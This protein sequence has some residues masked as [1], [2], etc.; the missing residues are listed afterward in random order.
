MAKVLAVRVRYQVSGPATCC[1]QQGSRRE[2]GTVAE[3]YQH[4][5]ILGAEGFWCASTI[6]FVVQK[7]LSKENS[8]GAEL[9][10]ARRTVS[11]GFGIPP[12]RAQE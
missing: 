2:N 9:S 1:E 11:P 12:G 5:S 3:R 10:H 7:A 4:I 8:D 6:T